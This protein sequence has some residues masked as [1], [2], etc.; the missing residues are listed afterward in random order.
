MQK[1]NKQKGSS[2]LG[3]VII[4][5]I[6]LFFIWLI[7]GGAQKANDQSLFLDNPIQTN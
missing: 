5:I 2:D 4:I 3:M 6:G 7:F 1:I